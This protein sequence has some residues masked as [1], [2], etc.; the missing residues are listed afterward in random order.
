MHAGNSY[1]LLTREGKQFTT[2]RRSDEYSQEV[3][4]SAVFGSV[5]FGLVGATVFGGIAAATS[6]ANE[7]EKYRLDLFDGTLFPYGMGDYT[8]ISSNVVLF[9]S[10]VSAPSAT[11]KV[12]ADDQY[13]CELSPGKYSVL[14]FSCHHATVKLK[15]ESSTGGEVSEAIDLHLL[16][17][18]AYLLRVMKDKSIV[19]NNLFD[20]VK[21]DILQQR[22]TEN[23]TCTT[24]FFENR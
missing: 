20:Q 1:M 24:E 9:L 21:K 8:Y 3:V 2:F 10:K 11:L 6:K 18:D 13:L 12:F 4:S 23:T 7:V 19:F 15:F 5:F 16:K 17:N 14:R 22:T